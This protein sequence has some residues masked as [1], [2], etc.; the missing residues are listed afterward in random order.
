MT[1]RDDVVAAWD[2]SERAQTIDA[3]DAWYQVAT[4]FIA[5]GGVLPDDMVPRYRLMSQGAQ[6]LPPVVVT[7]SPSPSWAVPLAVLVLAWFASRR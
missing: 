3:L 1:T 2:A 7:A 5:A 4:D 6:S